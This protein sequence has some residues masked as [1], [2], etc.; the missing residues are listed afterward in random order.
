MIMKISIRPCTLGRIIAGFYLLI[1]LVVFASMELDRNRYSY[2]LFRGPLNTFITDDDSFLSQLISPVAVSGGQNYST[3]I[4]EG[5][6]FYE[7]DTSTDAITF[8]GTPENEP[9]EWKQRIIRDAA[10]GNLRYSA[11]DKTVT[12]QTR[13][14][15]DNWQ[16]VNRYE[17]TDEIETI[18]EVA[19]SRNWLAVLSISGSYVAIYKISGQGR[20]LTLHRV[21][22]S[23]EDLPALMGA[24][25]AAFS[26]DEQLLVVS[27]YHGNGLVSLART[28]N[29]WGV[30]Q[31]LV[32]NQLT[33]LKH[34]LGPQ[35]VTFLNN[36]YL[37][38]SLNQ[39]H[40]LMSLRLSERILTVSDIKLNDLKAEIDF[41]QQDLLN[42][43]TYPGKLWQL[44]E[45]PDSA[46]T[47]THEGLR[48]VNLDDAG[49]IH[50]TGYWSADSQHPELKEATE[51]FIGSEPTF[52]ITVINKELNLAAV[53]SQLPDDVTVMMPETI[54][55]NT[56][57]QSSDY[58]V[59]KSSLAMLL[60][61]QLMALALG[62]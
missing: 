19:V 22:R 37:L 8:T 10:S 12:V 20:T 15:D 29:N 61:M 39:A 52:T 51:L 42:S 13:D 46:V 7:I 5:G 26:P 38:V 3:I 18:S 45:Q 11:F 43:F 44:P 50:L 55:D 21:F 2:N 16:E 32:K 54:A 1:P 31:Q 36:Q 4:T 9:V 40:G 49:N 33:R 41:P 48:F 62:Q 53:Y 30:I 58:P 35:G 6:H 14:G 34:L 25:S 23:S 28:G 56:S 59:V 60:M 27:G 17:L 24:H 57:T 47:T